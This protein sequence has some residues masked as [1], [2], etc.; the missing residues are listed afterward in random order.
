MLAALGVAVVA[1]LALGLWWWQLGA[2]ADPISSRPVNATAEV[3][4]SPAC[5]KGEQT[6]IRLTDTGTRTSLSGCGFGVGEVLSVQ[7]LAGQPGQVRLAG[8]AV[9]GDAPALH[10]LLPLGI[11]AAGLVAIVAVGGLLYRRHGVG[12]DS[13]HQPVSVATLMAR[14]ADHDRAAAAPSAELEANRGP[15]RGGPARSVHG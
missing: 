14:L 9:A 7:Y 10:R 3:L 4:S 8:T 13:E 5:G 12:R 15:T 2:A 1:V 6:A 11:G